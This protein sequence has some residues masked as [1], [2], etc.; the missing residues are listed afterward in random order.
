MPSI[1]SLLFTSLRLSAIALAQVNP[2]ES[3]RANNEVQSFAEAADLLP[4]ASL[5][6]VLHENFGKKYQDGIF[7]DDE[8][9][10]S[11]LHS[12]SPSLASKLVDLARHYADKVDLRKRQNDTAATTTAAAEPTAAVLV[13][14]ATTTA[15][16]VITVS[17]AAPSTTPAAQTTAQASPSGE[18]QSGT[19]SPT[20]TSPA[21][22]ASSAAQQT[23]AQ[24]VPTTFNAPVIETSA[25]Q[26][27]VDSSSGAQPTVQSTSAGSASSRQG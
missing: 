16:A 8:E 14:D 7:E 5:H 20:P 12:D 22:S 4:E 23:S 3:D 9:A 25:T 17:S 15:A 27:S 6:E 19:T 18:Q 10:I 26:L 21:S 24:S 11:A 2:S 13:T 1:R